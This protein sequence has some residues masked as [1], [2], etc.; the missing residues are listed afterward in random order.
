MSLETTPQNLFQFFQEALSQ[1]HS[2]HQLG[3]RM[4]RLIVEHPWYQAQLKRISHRVVRGSSGVVST[5]DIQQEAIL[6][7]ARS[8]QRRPDLRIRADQTPEQFSRCMRTIIL[9]DCRQAL[10]RLRRGPDEVPLDEICL[11]VETRVP[12]DMAI[13]LDERLDKLSGKQ[14]WVVRQYLHG[15]SLAEISEILGVGTTTVHRT[16]QSAIHSLRPFLRPE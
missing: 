14:Q 4:W 9:H 7:L 12:I 10:R 16:L 6:L 15:R 2:A 11:A 8:C 3:P 5:E 1:V 13:D